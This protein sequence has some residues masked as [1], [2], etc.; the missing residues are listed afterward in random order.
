LLKELIN[1]GV[2]EAQG[3]ISYAEIELDSPTLG[4]LALRYQVGLTRQLLEKT[5][6][7]TNNE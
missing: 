4:G 2:G 5:E 3:G 7:C 6:P 1:E